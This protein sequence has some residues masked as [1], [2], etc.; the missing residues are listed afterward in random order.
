MLALAI[1]VAVREPAVAQDSERG[2]RLVEPGHWAYEYLARLRS[3][4]YLGD[5]DPLAQPYHQADIVRALSQLDPDTLRPPVSGWVKLLRSEFSAPH[6]PWGAVLMAGARAANTDRLDP[7]RPVGDGDVWPN[8][9]AGVWFEGGH[10]AAESR[11]VGDFYLSHDPELRAPHRP[12]GGQSDHT[13]VSVSVP[14]AS[15]LLGR[16]A[17]NWGPAGTRGLLISDDPPTYP[18][19]GFEGRFGRFGFEAFTAELDTLEGSKRYLAAQRLA[20]STTHFTIAAA[21]AIMY[22]GPNLPLSLALLNPVSVLALEHEN[23]PSDDRNQNF[24]AS[25]QAWYQVRG[26]VLRGEFLLD[27]VDLRT[28]PGYSRAPT[29]YGFTAGA[30]LLALAP[31]LE[32]SA[33]YS[34]V[35]SF[36]YRSFGPGNRY[37]YLGRG[38]GENFA[39]HDRW[40]IAADLFPPIPGLTLTP[41][42]EALRQGEGDF[43]VAMPSDSV[44]RISP[45][46]L[47]GIAERTY[48]LGVRGR[49]QPTRHL[50]LSWDVGRNVVRN[51]DHELDRRRSEFVVLGEMGL[52]FEFGPHPR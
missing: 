34:Q 47:L 13:Y 21:D 48:R 31:W 20:Y 23:P 9:T 49:Y 46:L 27:D 40:S 16:I 37:D 25:V 1:A 51:A 7:L 41:T 36:A 2:S 44:F 43:R 32:L 10:V 38:L 28:I 12:I 39:D 35:S 15:V 22:S 19:L 5:L 30:R 14:F 11:V 45:N 3:R 24:M 8:G 17:R 6:Q 4:G 29:R 18:Q 52:R 26:L 33:D 42:F 50:W